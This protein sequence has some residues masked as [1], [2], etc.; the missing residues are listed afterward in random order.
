MPGD[1]CIVCGNT[2]KKDR[3]VSLHCLPKEKSKRLRW[4]KALE[5]SEDRVERHHRVC[6]R[7]FS[8]G[9]ARKDPQLSLGKRFVSPKKKW[10]D[11]RREPNNRRQLDAYLPIARQL[12]GVH[13][14]KKTRLWQFIARQLLG[15]HQ[16]RKT[17]L[18]Q[19]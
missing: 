4:L 18:W 17:C 5:L 13:Q 16:L 11:K 9:N 14:L 8:E 7:H 19:F 12:L 3:S 1:T 10:T 2:R 6:S 15:V